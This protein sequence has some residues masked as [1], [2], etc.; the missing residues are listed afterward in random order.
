MRHERVTGFVPYFVM[1]PA[2]LAAFGGY[3]GSVLWLTYISLTS[4][5]SLP[6]YSLTGTFQYERLF[7]S[8]RWMISLQNMIVIGFG[9]ILLTLAVGTL[10]AIALDQKV[11][12][13]GLFRT[14]FLYPYSMSFIVTGLAWQ[15]LLNPQHGIGVVLNEIGLGFIDSQILAK[16]ETA[17]WAVIA[18]FVWQEVGLSVVIILSALRA[19]DNDIWKAGKVDGIPVWRMYVSVVLPMMGPAFLTSAFLMILGVVSMYELVLALTGGGPGIAT[20]V[21]TKFIMDYLFQRANIGLAAAASLTLFAM[22][23]VLAGGFFL[24]SRRS[25]T[26]KALRVE[27]IQ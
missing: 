2:Y 21:P 3:V 18:A 6:N 27:V 23:L 20:E 13:E 1:S 5:K 16:P 11:K 7:H 26:R 22:V 25:A 14:V 17:L 12:G 4:S 19:V 8:S 9:G 15:W 24:F 10:I